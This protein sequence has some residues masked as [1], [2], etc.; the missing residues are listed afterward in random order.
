MG[1]V[2]RVWKINSV[3]FYKVVNDLNISDQLKALL[4]SKFYDETDMLAHKDEDYLDL[5]ELSV[6]NKY[7]DYDEKFKIYFDDNYEELKEV[8]GHKIDS[9]ILLNNLDSL[10]IAIERKYL[11]NEIA[12]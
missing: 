6:W 4:I 8:Y 7:Y 11:D 10:E 5:M 2:Q 1:E 9:I 3:A 12:I